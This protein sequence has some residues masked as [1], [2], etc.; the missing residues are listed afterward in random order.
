MN[1]FSEMILAPFSAAYAATMRAREKLYRSGVF[2]SHGIEAPVISVGNITTGGTGK[3]PLVAWL[4][5]T[6]ARENVRVCI[7]T[8]GYGRAN[9][10][11]RV[12]VSDGKN[13]LADA[14]AGGDEPYLLAEK[15]LKAG[16]A[17]ISDRD[18][19]AAAQWALAELGSNLFI[20]DDGFQHLRLKRDLDI[21][22]VDA[23]NPFGG[24]HLLPRGRLREPL[25]A[26]KRADCIVI[27]R[28][29]L[30]PDPQ[31]L[32]ARL[33]ELSDNR[34]ALLSHTRTSQVRPLFAATTSG[35][36]DSL[37]QPVAAFC[38]IG[39]GS[40]FFSQ[41]T[42]DGYD[43]CY[44]QRFRDHH[45]YTQADINELAR[46]AA[47]KGAQAVLTTAKDAVKLRS[48]EFPLPCYV[49]EI[50][51]EFDDVDT[52]LEMLRKVSRKAA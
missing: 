42:R 34:P 25:V 48:I 37:R 39:N 19:F 17:V 36:G 22:T 28:A 5:R 46:E 13:I 51:I 8:R 23:T 45:N 43:L 3:T 40:A 49:V 35:T 50:E 14:R 33:R 9:P 52:L 6:L 18:R 41:L 7:L 38:A 30:I 32:R 2:A 16:V 31:A 10:K 4:A 24:G 29:D 11:R 21:I 27:T 26:L 47:T 20:L 44:T 15:L 12:V 1:A